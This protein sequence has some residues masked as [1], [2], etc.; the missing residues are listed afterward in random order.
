M[1]TSSLGTL[2]FGLPNKVTH[3]TGS[4]ALCRAPD[5]K[6]ELVPVN[7]NIDFHFWRVYHH[8]TRLTVIFELK[9]KCLVLDMVI[10]YTLAI[11]HISPSLL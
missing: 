11:F 1:S 6:R 7:C 3:P 8:I 4:L 9:E 5:T 10:I 2:L